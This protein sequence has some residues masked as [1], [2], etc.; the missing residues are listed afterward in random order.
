MKRTEK[1]ADILK[2][3]AIVLLFATLIIM[4]YMH[5]GILREK[6]EEIPSSSELDG[7]FSEKEDRIFG[8]L[9]ED[10]LLPSDVAVKNS[11]GEVYAISA[12][13]D[14]MNE[15]Y[16][17][18]TG[19]VFYSLGDTCC[20]EETSRET[21]YNAVNADSMIY[22]RYHSALPAALLYMH[23][24]D[25]IGATKESGINTDTE[26]VYLREMIIFPQNKNIGE[27]YAIAMSDSGKALSFKRLKDTATD[28]IS[29][30]ELE[31]Y[32]KAGAMTPCS[33]YGYSED[34]YESRA[35][36]PTTVIY[37]EPSSA[38]KLF[39]SY[40][41]QKTSDEADSIHSKFA[42][43]F[44][45][46]PDK[47]GSYYDEESNSK[48]YMAT[49][50]LLLFS[51]NQVSYST[52]SGTTGVSLSYYSG[53]GSEHRHTL[54]EQILVAE[55]IIHSLKNDSTTENLIGGEATPQITGIFRQGNNLTVEYGLFYDNLPIEAYESSI[56]IQLN[57]SNLTSFEMGFVRVIPNK[58]EVIR[59]IS[60]S[61]IVSMLEKSTEP[62]SE[63]TVIYK[64]SHFGEKSLTA[65]WVPVKIGGSIA[66]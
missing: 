53:K 55:A 8:K 28:L 40:T 61:W 66:Q 6:S 58:N 24:C 22:L 44:N 26:A 49:H 51:N 36:K 41:L 56:R 59:P 52:K 11:L 10:T 2:T 38:H 60:P 27:T 3:A 25:N 30:S 18:L 65:E 14:Y 16:S 1:A 23:A 29:L 50:G 57:E 15:V 31:I 35:V 20:A 43:L 19:S 39:V 46:N 9:C 17:L 5:Y 34:T 4:V 45:I 21:F 13:S 42:E 62:S 47:V 48:I 12:G 7:Y 63:Y 64:Y 37:S 54:Y 32:W 33:F